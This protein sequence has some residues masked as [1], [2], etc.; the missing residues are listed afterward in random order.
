MLKIT[1]KGDKIDVFPLE[2]YDLGD[3]TQAII[4]HDNSGLGPG[5]YLD[6][7]FIENE[8]TK[9]RWIFVCD[10][11]LDKMEGDRQIVR[12]LVPGSGDRTTYIVRVYT[13]NEKDAGTDA[14]IA[15]TIVGSGGK[16]VKAKLDHSDKKNKFEKGKIDT[17]AVDSQD[18]GELTTITLISDGK[19]VGADWKVDKVEIVDQANCNLFR[20]ASNSW[21]KKGELTIKRSEMG[22]SQKLVDD[23]EKDEGQSE[24]PV[25]E[26]ST[27]A[28]PQSSTS[29]NEKHEKKRKDSKEKHEKKRK[30]SKEKPEKEKKK[31]G[32]TDTNAPAPEKEKKK[33]KLG[34]F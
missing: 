14:N 13:A 4:E 24:E 3:L 5:W 32:S 26:K 23:S 1:L 9:K 34:I 11:W 12:A 7:I 28:P 29:T 22:R 25:S 20:F 31:K 19:G 33:K 18:L 8:T 6:K 17:F 15:I 2:T 21:L 30:D 16:S 27:S 10:N